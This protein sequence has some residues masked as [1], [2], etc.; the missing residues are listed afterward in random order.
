LSKSVIGNISYTKNSETASA[1]RV[2]KIFSELVK[3]RI[4]IMVSLTTA[5]GY[6]L[7][8]NSISYKIIFPVAGIFLLACASSALNQ[9]QERFSDALM[10]R[11]TLRP[12]PSG[13][14]NANSV[15]LFSIL[16]LFT[17]I[18]LMFITT[19]FAAMFVGVY[20]FAWYNFVYTPLK[21]VSSFAIIPGS[22]VGA[23]PPIAGWLAAG[24]ELLDLKILGFALYLFIWQIPHFWLLVMIYGKDYSTAGFPSLEKYFNREQIKRISF[25]WLVA[26]VGVALG[27]IFTG[28]LNFI[29]TLAALILFSAWMIYN[30]VVF[31]MSDAENKIVR[32]TFIKINFYTLML[33]ILLS[34][35]KLLF[36]I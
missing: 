13:R 2:M 9:Y 31:L 6:I 34:I 20:T 19:N 23:L 15:L 22:L 18:V 24:G 10:Q 26:T 11:T 14:I 36:I 7:A 27:L 30:A 3:L 17:G 4:T 21:K 1:Y 35:D 33:I 16:T 25:Y 8:S 5:L 32:N 12:I 29:I 28:S